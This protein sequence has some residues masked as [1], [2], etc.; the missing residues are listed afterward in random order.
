MD[1][2]ERALDSLLEEGEPLVETWTVDS[3]TR[4]LEFSPPG[5][6][7]TETVGLTDRRLVWLDDELETVDLAD[8]TSVGIDSV[9]QSTTSLLLV[10]GPIATVLGAIV[11]A[12]LWLFTSLPGIVTVAPLGLG[13]FVLLA[14][15]VGSRLQDTENIERQYYL[16]VKTTE[17]TVQVYATESTVESMNERITASLE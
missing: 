8:V 10:T 11:T 1:P 3:T 5:L 14:A 9:G 4:G 13:V 2:S 17:T 6:G 7:G 15:V 12:V 16:D